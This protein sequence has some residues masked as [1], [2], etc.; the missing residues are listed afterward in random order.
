MVVVGGP[1]LARCSS[2]PEHGAPVSQAQDTVSEPASASQG[3]RK[4]AEISVGHSCA[5]P[6]P[7]L[8]LGAHVTSSSG[9]SPDAGAESSS[10][11][12]AQT[13]PSTATQ[14]GCRAASSEAAAA[15]GARGPPPGASA[16][17][18]VGHR[19]CV[20]MGHMPVSWKATLLRL[21][22]PCGQGSPPSERA[23]REPPGAAAAV[24][25]AANPQGSDP[26]A[27]AHLDGPRDAAG[28][29]G[30]VPGGAREVG[31]VRPGQRVHHAALRQTSVSAAGHS[32]SGPGRAA[33]C[34]LVRQPAA[35]RRTPLAP[36]GSTNSA[37]A[38]ASVVL[39]AA[40]LAVCT[41]TTTA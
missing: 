11:A 4:A 30:A 13:W 17:V 19:P 15:A 18:V 12:Q 21:A 22:T 6:A 9:G 35:R 36:A 7:G 41:A 37:L 14:A 34:K 38:T 23:M 33:C 8:D 39:G 1:A 2:A 31:R 16:P 24:Q 5:V 28:G 20:A 29:Q 26:N 3:S 40:R 27:Q 32:P 25:G 10:G